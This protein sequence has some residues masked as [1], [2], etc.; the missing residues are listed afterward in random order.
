MYVGGGRKL[1]VAM[2]LLLVSFSLHVAHC[3]K[4]MGQTGPI[5]PG[6][7]GAARGATEG[8]E[9]AAAHFC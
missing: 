7:C 4:V 8:E 5:S 9:Q 2:H 3:S 6:L 1:L